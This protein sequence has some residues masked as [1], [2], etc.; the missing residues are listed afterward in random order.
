MWVEL[1]L[2]P[3]NIAIFLTEVVL[4]FILSRIE[5]KGAIPVPCEISTIY[6]ASAGRRRILPRRP[7]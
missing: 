1:S 3:V 6:L 4:D 7:I 5:I 2:T